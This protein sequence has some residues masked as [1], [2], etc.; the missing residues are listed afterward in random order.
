MQRFSAIACL[1]LIAGCIG[2]DSGAAVGDAAQALTDGVD[3][4]GFL[5][6]YTIQYS[7]Q[8]KTDEIEFTR[9]AKHVIDKHHDASTLIG[10][11]W[12]EKV[13]S[14]RACPADLIKSYQAENKGR[15]PASAS[16]LL[17]VTAG[18]KYA[19]NKRELA[20]ALETAQNIIGE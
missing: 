13:C 7:R 20:E 8:H 4:E 17:L 12:R 6:W 10:R 15:L 1:A 9:V 11:R 5:E 2:T 18:R 19:G 3:F 16:P 14:A